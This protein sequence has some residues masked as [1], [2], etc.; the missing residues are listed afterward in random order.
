M[1]VSG[2]TSSQA[3]F[4]RLLDRDLEAI[5]IWLP[6]NLKVTFGTDQSE[7]DWLGWCDIT[8]SQ[9]MLHASLSGAMVYLT[10]LHEIGHAL[11]LNH[12]REGIMAHS[13]AERRQTLTLRSR[14]KWLR[15][16]MKLLIRKNL[17]I[18][19]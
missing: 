3:K 15:Q 16:L 14:R 6:R 17:K 1:Q 7:D 19:R 10:L 11:G 2:A 5:E 9:I 4:V 8:E 13:L 18:L 12:T